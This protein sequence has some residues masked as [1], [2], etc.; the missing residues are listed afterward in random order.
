MSNVPNP[1]KNKK[2]Y[3]NLQQ[4]KNTTA[5]ERLVKAVSMGLLHL[6]H[7][8]E[9]RIRRIKQTVVLLMFWILNFCSTLLLHTQKSINHTIVRFQA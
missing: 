5:M 7:I 9:P 2:Q 4:S 8:V 3:D 1:K 6:C